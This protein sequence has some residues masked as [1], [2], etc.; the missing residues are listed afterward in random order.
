M[1]DRRIDTPL[2][3]LPSCRL[4]MPPPSTREGATALRGNPYLLF[5]F[6]PGVRR[7]QGV[8]VTINSLSMRGVEP[9]RPKPNGVMRFITTGDSSVFGFGVE[10]NEVF[11]S[12]A[13]VNLNKKALY[14]RGY[15]RGCARLLSLSPSIFA[16]TRIKN[17]AR[18]FVVAN[19]WSDNNFDFLSIRTSCHLPDTNAHS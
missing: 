7:E 15:Q 13:A 9:A 5:E 10:D 18:S 12:V 1:V 14:V 16:P 11:S 19:I 17:R 2:F 6:A 4:G 3:T 8:T